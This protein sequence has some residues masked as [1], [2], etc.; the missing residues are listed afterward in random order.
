MTIPEAVGLILQAASQANGGEIFVLD[1]GEPI[2]IVDLA[3]Q[4]IEL[5]GHKPNED[6]KIEF[7]G[8]R[9]GEK[10]FE[11]VSHKRELL[12][13][14]EHPKIL[15]F[16]SQPFNFPEVQKQIQDMENNICQLEPDQIKLK[17][18]NSSLNMC[19]I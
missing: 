6:I 15:R 13:E 2:K 3:N 4:L 16:V 5:H 9:P 17:L 11:E 12:K 8:L 1:M 7:I 10:L 19:R 14:T 18:Q